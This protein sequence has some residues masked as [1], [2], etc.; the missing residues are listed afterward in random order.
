[1]K[2]LLAAQTLSLSV[3]ASLSYLLQTKHP[4]FKDCEASIKFITILNYKLVLCSSK[5][6]FGR[7]FKAP[8]N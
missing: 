5:S 2:T 7:G 6:K 4:D 8:I 1:M 3:A